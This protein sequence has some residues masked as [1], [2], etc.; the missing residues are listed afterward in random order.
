M[1]QKFLLP[2]GKPTDRERIAGNV[3]TFLSALPDTEAW[4]IAIAR[5][6]KRRSRQANAF[7]WAALY[8][9]LVHSAGFTP[10]EWHEYFLGGFFGWRDVVK[11]G[12]RKESVPKRSTTKNERGERDVLD[13]KTFDAFL[14]YV[15]SEAAQYGVWLDVEAEAA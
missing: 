1:T 10:D 13:P 5:A 6:P 8:A 12:G 2:A 15:Q 4:E 14:L 7:M 11:P 9:P 3:A